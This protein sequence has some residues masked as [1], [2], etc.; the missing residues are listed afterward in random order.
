MRINYGQKRWVPSFYSERACIYGWCS[1]GH[2][3]TQC[4]K[5][6][7]VGCGLVGFSVVIGHGPVEGGDIEA[8]ASLLDEVFPGVVDWGVPG[9]RVKLQPHWDALHQRDPTTV[10]QD[11]SSVVA[12]S[13]HFDHSKKLV[14]TLQPPIIMWKRDSSV[15]HIYMGIHSLT[16]LQVYANSKF[17]LHSWLSARPLIPKYVKVSWEFI[18]EQAELIMNCA[19]PAVVTLVV[20]VAL[21]VLSQVTTFTSSDSC[22]Q[23]ASTSITSWPPDTDSTCSSTTITTINSNNNNYVNKGDDNFDDNK[24]NKKTLTMTTITLATFWQQ[25]VLKQWDQITKNHNHKTSVSY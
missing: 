19:A 5:A 14:K 4:S 12:W 10:T 1:Y 15:E 6:H 17:W 16:G 7:L 8:A 18:S 9:A 11:Q 22:P 21:S 23:W 20:D 13:Q 2:K 24:N 3:T 25:W